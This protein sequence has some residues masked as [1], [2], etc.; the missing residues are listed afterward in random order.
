MNDVN[1]KEI[2]S[3][4]S[5]S[6]TNICTEDL[7]CVYKK[8]RSDP[9]GYFLFDNYFVRFILFSIAPAVAILVIFKFV[10]LSIDLNKYIEMLFPISVIWLFFNRSTIFLIIKLSML[11]YSYLP[12]L[13]FQYLSTGEIVKYKSLKNSIFILFCF[14]TIGL[15][16]QV[17]IWR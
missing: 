10:L 9:I 13:N 2:D 3:F 15:I 5:K 4:H 12:F 1:F 14:L 8:I 6:S 16:M 11:F 17:A 7:S